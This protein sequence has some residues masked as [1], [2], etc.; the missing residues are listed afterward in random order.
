MPQTDRAPG[1]AAMSVS[2]HIEFKWLDLGE[3][4]GCLQLVDDRLRH[5]FVHIQERNPARP[6]V[7]LAMFTPFSPIV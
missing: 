6:R 7:K 3:Q 1:R 2:D 5:F 4:P